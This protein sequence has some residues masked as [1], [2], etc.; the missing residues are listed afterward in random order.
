MIIN[1]PSNT[2]IVHV[3]VNTCTA[4]KLACVCNV[5][6]SQRWIFLKSWL[7][8]RSLP[9]RPAKN[10]HEIYSYWSLAVLQYICSDFSIVLYLV[11][12]IWIVRCVWFY[13]DF[14]LKG[15][16]LRPSSSPY[17]VWW[18]VHPWLPSRLQLLRWVW[19]LVFELW[20]LSWWI[21]VWICGSYYVVLPMHN[22]IGFRSAYIQ[23]Y[24]RVMTSSKN[25]AH[26]VKW[27]PWEI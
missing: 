7:S 26:T 27:M 8:I 16:T 25:K 3:A 12:L 17:T 22:V 21:N 2:T 15:S 4:Q 14:R 24:A 23:E 20:P 19:K 11:F 6:P 1:R 10:I 18:S 13:T 5:T 9:Y